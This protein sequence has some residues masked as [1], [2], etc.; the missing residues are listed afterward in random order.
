VSDGL[1][2]RKISP[3]EIAES[4]RRTWAHSLHTTDNLVIGG[5]VPLEGFA[6]EGGGGALGDEDK[7]KG[8]G[9][10]LI[11]ANGRNGERK[12]VEDCWRIPVKSSSFISV[13]RT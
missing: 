8:C 13:R 4:L 12:L 5:I 1:G 9:A 2:V 3:M 11:G 10:W 6:A 7:C